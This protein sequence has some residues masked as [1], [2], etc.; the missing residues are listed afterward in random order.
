MILLSISFF[1]FLVF[2]SV[3]P[4]IGCRFRAVDEADLCQ[5]LTAR[6]RIISVSRD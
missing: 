2:F 3:F 1:Y 6:Y 4:L 5:L